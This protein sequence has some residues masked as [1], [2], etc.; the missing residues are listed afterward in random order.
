VLYTCVTLTSRGKNTI[1]E[2]KY[3][4]LIAYF[5]SNISAKERPTAVS[6]EPETRYGKQMTV[7][8]R[9]LCFLALLL[10]M[11]ISARR[12]WE[13]SVFVAAHTAH[14]HVNDVL[15]IVLVFSINTAQT[16]NHLFGPSKGDDTQC[17][18]NWHAPLFQALH[19]DAFSLMLSYF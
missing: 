6:V 13:A 10:S 15:F 4:V 2:K 9:F 19:W 8:G 17:Q 12:Y 16:H 3:I 1:D 11:P 5:L 18:N 14:M 7:G